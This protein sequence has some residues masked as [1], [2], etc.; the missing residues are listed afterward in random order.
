MKT[1]ELKGLIF[2][3]LE[4]EQTPDSFLLKLEEAGV[5]YTFRED[6][7]QKVLNRIVGGSPAGIAESEFL[8]SMRMVF[9]RVALTG[10]AAII[11]LLISILLGQGTLS[12]DSILGIGDFQAESI[13]CLMTGY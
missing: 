13:I 6:L 1:E 8:S 11:L 4:T 5:K 3:A 10:V 7:A 12:L 9:Y 2:K